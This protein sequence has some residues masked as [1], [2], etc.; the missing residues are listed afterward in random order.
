VIEDVPGKVAEMLL[1]LFRRFRRAEEK[2]EFLTE[3]PGPLA[4]AVGDDGTGRFP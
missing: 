3:K 2:T 1:R 4:V